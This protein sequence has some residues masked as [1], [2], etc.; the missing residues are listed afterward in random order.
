MTLIFIMF[1]VECNYCIENVPNDLN[2]PFTYRI[3]NEFLGVLN[4]NNRPQERLLLFRTTQKNE[5]NILYK[6]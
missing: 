6:Q 2:A 5:L 4:N 3:F 1:N